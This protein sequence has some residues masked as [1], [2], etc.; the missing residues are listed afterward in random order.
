MYAVIKTGG[1]QFQVSEGDVI[2]VEKLEGQP[3]DTVEID[4]VLMLRTDSDVKIGTPLVEGAAVSATILDQTKG[5]KIIVYKFKRRK[6]YRR[7]Q[8]HRQKYTKL[9]I[10][11][12]KVS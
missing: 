5:K 12:I 10:D 3:G 1:K 7:K 6:D 9:R 11:A 2:Q 4:E 8:G